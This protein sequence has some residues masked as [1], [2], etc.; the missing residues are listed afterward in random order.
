MTLWEIFPFHFNSDE[1]STGHPTISADGKTVYFSSDRPGGFG[2]VDIYVTNLNQDSSW[3]EPKNLDSLINT[4]G[5]ELFPFFHNNTKTL[6]FASNGHVGLGGL[7]I[8]ATQIEGSKMPEN[9]G[10]P[11][12]TQFDD[13]G[14]IINHKQKGGFFSSNRKGGEGHDDIYGFTVKKP[15]VEK[16]YLIGIAFFAFNHMATSINF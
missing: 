15:L 5:N 3:S 14:L 13:F 4:E 2:G 11:I 8:F 16:K 9:L 1:Y 7:D 6:Y 10:H 12:N